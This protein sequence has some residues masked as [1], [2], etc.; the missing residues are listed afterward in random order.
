MTFY[1]K[2]KNKEEEKRKKMMMRKK[3][4]TKRKMMKKKAYQTTLCRNSLAFSSLSLKMIIDNGSQA[5]KIIQS[6]DKK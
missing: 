5:G 1:C 2:K 3:T 4:R 6:L